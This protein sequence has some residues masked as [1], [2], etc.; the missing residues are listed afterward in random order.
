[1]GD[2]LVAQLSKLL[3]TDEFTLMYQLIEVLGIV[4]IVLTVLAALLFS[5]RRINKYAFSNKNAALKKIV[6]PL[7]KAHPIIG[8]LLLISAYLHGDLALGSM[9]RVHTGPLTWWVLLVMMLVAMIG[10]RFKIKN[11]IKIHRVLAIIMALSVLLHLFA[12]NILG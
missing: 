4:N 2:F 10:R 12:R 8:F 6:K 9:F 7:S 5:L 11:W 3:G 1:M